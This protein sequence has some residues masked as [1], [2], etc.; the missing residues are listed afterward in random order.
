MSLQEPRTCPWLNRLWTNNFQ[1]MHQWIRSLLIIWIGHT[2][3]S[4]IPV[5]DTHKMWLRNKLGCDFCSFWRFICL[6]ISGS[7]SGCRYGWTETRSTHWTCWTRTVS[8]R[9]RK[10]LDATLEV[11]DVSCALHFRTVQFPV[12]LS[13]LRNLINQRQ[14]QNVLQPKPNLLRSEPKPTYPRLRAKYDCQ[15]QDWPEFQQLLSQ[16]RTCDC[17]LNLHW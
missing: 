1:V 3:F 8:N 12:G 14:N 16:P 11:F 4:R 15:F 5:S 6:E 7:Q 17:K 10:N 2:L 9:N 13:T